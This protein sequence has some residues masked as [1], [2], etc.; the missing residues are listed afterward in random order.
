MF[1]PSLITIA[2]ALVLG[3]ASE[4]AKPQASAKAQASADTDVEAIAREAGWKPLGPSLWF[5]PRARRLIVR[6]RVVLREGPLEHLL[7][8][9]GTKEHEAILATDAVPYQ[10]HAGLLAT[11]ALK[12]QP[13]QFVPRFVAPTGTAIAI[14]LRWLQ[15]GKSQHADARTWVRDERAGSTLKDRLGLRRQRCWSKIR[16]PRSRFTP[17]RTAT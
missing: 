7:C 9:K 1:P 13:V 14:E 10:I 5:D 12:G 17:P 15:D 16:F 3:Q 4:P 11:G 2:L 8:L 6:G